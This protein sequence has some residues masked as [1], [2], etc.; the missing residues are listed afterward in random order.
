[1]VST[2]FSDVLESVRHWWSAHPM[3][4]VGLVASEAANAG[5]LPAL[6]VLQRCSAPRR[7]R[8][9]WAVFSS[10]PRQSGGLLALPL[11]E[12]WRH[13]AWPS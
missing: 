10:S 1:M 3:R 7:L 9:L 12:G 5:A 8:A 13:L 6:L 11:P 4:P 2:A